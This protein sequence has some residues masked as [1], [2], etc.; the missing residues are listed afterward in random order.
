MNN[1]REL[2]NTALLWHTAHARRMAIGAEKRKL[3]AAIKAAG[4]GADTWPLRSRECQV[5]RELTEARRK[6]LAALRVLGKA[7]AKQRGHLDL[8]D[9]VLDGAVRL[10]PCAD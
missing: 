2:V 6:E 1:D 4:N 7:C 5:A 8:A 9:V 10:L 3:G